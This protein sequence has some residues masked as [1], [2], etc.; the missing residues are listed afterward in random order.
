ME[1]DTDMKA[2]YD[3]AY[4]RGLRDAQRWLPIADAPPNCVHL[5]ATKMPTS[6]WVIQLAHFVP[7]YT[8]ESTEDFAEY[9]GEKDE[10]YTQEGWYEMC[11]EHDEY[12]SM[13][14]GIDPTH[15]QPLP[16]PPEDAGQ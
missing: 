7:R 8:V 15:F 10:Y 2:I 11:Y 12:S 16:P 3:A 1:P 14:M 13:M 9:C 4:A 6:R 5:V